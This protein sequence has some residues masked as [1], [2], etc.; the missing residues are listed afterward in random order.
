MGRPSATATRPGRALHHSR[1][2][3]HG[4]ACRT[5]AESARGWASRDCDT[6]TRARLWCCITALFIAQAEIDDLA[7]TSRVPPARCC[8]DRRVCRWARSGQRLERAIETR[9]RQDA[10]RF[11][12]PSIG[13][14]ILIPCST[15][16]IWVS[17]AADFGPE[18]VFE[19]SVKAFNA[20]YIV[21][22]MGTQV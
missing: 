15:G 21:M 3:A 18:G 8:A 16:C 6:A 13:S 10:A 11:S 5:V 1:T 19:R 9:S 4:L 14:T 7:R 20:S 12:I 17:A 2:T 22:L